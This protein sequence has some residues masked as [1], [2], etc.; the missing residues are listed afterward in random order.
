MRTI[1]K[2]IFQNDSHSSNLK[3]KKKDSSICEYERDRVVELDHK[4]HKR[5]EKSLI[6]SENFDR[7]ASFVGILGKEELR[8]GR[9][10]YHGIWDLKM[11]FRSNLVRRFSF[12]V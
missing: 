8:V 7:L 6:S 12:L 3:I 1:A 2:F 4:D 9:L 5:K 10:G 11:K